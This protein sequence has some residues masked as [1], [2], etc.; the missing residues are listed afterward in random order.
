MQ[1][2]FVILFYFF[3]IAKY[4]YEK[5]QEIVKKKKRNVFR[6]KFNRVTKLHHTLHNEPERNFLQI[7]STHIY[8]PS[9]NAYRNMDINNAMGTSTIYYSRLM[10][11]AIVFLFMFIMVTVMGTYLY[12]SNLEQGSIKKRRHNPTN[13]YVVN[14]N[15]PYS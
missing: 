15:V 8:D 7:R 6:N 4:T 1:L 12:L 9:V 2:R 14:P 10:W 13:Y 11:G 3:F 5:N